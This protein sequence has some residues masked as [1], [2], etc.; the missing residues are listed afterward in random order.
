M[1]GHVTVESGLLFKFFATLGALVY[2]PAGSLP[3]MLQHV[4]LQP[5][6]LD[7]RCTTHRAHVWLFSRVKTRVLHQPFFL[8][9]SSI[10][11]CA[12][13]RL[14]A[15]VYRLVDSQ[16]IFLSEAFTTHC[17]HVR[18]LACVYTHVLAQVPTTG[19]NYPAHLTLTR[20]FLRLTLPPSV[21]LVV[22]KTGKGG[23]C[24]TTHCALKR[25]L[26]CVLPEMDFQVAT[27]C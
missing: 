12:L 24:F 5:G 27:A 2:F 16:I 1:N 23:E 15:C 17:A 3:Y 22:L 21:D 26:S 9:E 7:E 19:Q 20:V 10:T 14:L 4:G 18:L 8:S 25:F 11:H 6:F 13:E